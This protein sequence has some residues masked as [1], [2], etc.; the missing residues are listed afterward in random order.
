MKHTERNT[1]RSNGLSR[2]II[3]WDLPTRVFH[4]TMAIAFFVA[5]FTRGS[6]QNLDLHVFAGYTMLGLIAFRLVWGTIGGTYARFAQFSLHRQ[7]VQRYAATL[8]TPRRQRYIGHN[9]LASVAIVALIL[10]STLTLLTGLMVLGGQKQ[11]GPLADWLTF[12]QGALLNPVHEW[13]ATALLALVVVHVLGAVTESLLHGDNLIASMIH[14]RRRTTSAAPSSANFSVLG[15]LLVTVLAI[16][17][18]VSYWPWLMQDAHTPY[19]PFKGPALFQ[20]AAWQDECGSCHL[21]YHPSLLPARSWQAMLATQDTHF[22]E[23]LGLDA[24]TIDELARYA[25]AQAAELHQTEAAW[26]IDRRVAPSQIP[27]RISDT[28]YW[29]AKHRSLTDAVWRMQEI[30]SKA[31]CDA[32]HSD[33]KSGGF[34]PAAMRIPG[35]PSERIRQTLQAYAKRVVLMST[36][37]AD[38]QQETLP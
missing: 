35:A 9:P 4:W 1:P 29:K 36:A 24:A 13:L 31:N 32:C 3:V 18:G 7:Q 21:A 34:Q 8:L 17:A 25:V 26:Q 20:N 22:G 30:K 6:A 28:R 5:W 11:H 23:N 2:Q 19:Q 27:Q 33:A 12:D 38:T 16:A 37:A 15:V 14:G 10:L